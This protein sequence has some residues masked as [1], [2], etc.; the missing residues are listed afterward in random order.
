LR[1]TVKE[2]QEYY[3]ALRAWQTILRDPANILEIAL[4]PGLV[5]CFDNWR[6]LHGRNSFIGKRRMCGC[7]HGADDWHSRLRVLYEKAAAQNEK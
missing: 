7:Y 4:P 3:Y 5:V 1:L 2:T 6:V